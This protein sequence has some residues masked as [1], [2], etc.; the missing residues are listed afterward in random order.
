[1][2]LFEYHPTELCTVSGQ[3]TYMLM[4]SKAWMVFCGGYH[5]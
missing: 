5:F 2:Q 3:F 4:I 1:V